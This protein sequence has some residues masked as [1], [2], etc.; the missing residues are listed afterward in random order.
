MISL[1]FSV[2]FA[3]AVDGGF[4]AHGFRLAAHDADARDPMVGWRPGS[5]TRHSWFASGVMEYANQPLV[6]ERS[7]SSVVEVDDQLVLNTSLGYAPHPRIRLD[8]GLPVFFYSRGVAG[9]IGP[10]L[11]DLR[12]TGL[13]S[14]ISPE[15]GGLGLGLVGNLDVPT[16]SQRD[17]RGQRTVAGGVGVAVTGELGKLTLSASASSQLRPNSDPA[18]RPAPTEGGDAFTWAASV[19][20]LVT[21]TT[22]L[23][24]EAYGEAASDREV[25]TALGI[26]VEAMLSMR[27]VRPSGGFLTAGLG[28][29]L[30]RGAGAS[31]FRLIVGGGFGRG[32]KVVQDM[33][34]DGFGDYDDLC[35]ASPET[36]N[37]YK[38]EDGCP[39]ELPRMQFRA[40]DPGGEY[41]EDATVAVTG[42]ENQT[43]TGSLSFQ[44]EAVTPGSQWHV[45]VTLGNCLA[46]AAD[47]TMGPNGDEVDVVLERK[48]TARVYVEAVDLQGNPVPNAEVRFRTEETPCAP[49]VQT[50]LPD[51]TAEVPV[52]P[53]MF[54][55]FVTAPGY[56]VHQAMFQME[57]SG[58]QTVRAVLEPALAAMIE[59]PDGT[60]V[61]EIREKVYFDTGKATILD[62]S[63]GLLDV[64]ASVIQSEGLNQV[65]VGGHTDDRGAAAANEELSRA[66]ADAVRTYLIG[67][68]VAPGLLTAV[69]YG[70]S[71]PLQSNATT[72]GRDAN[73]R[74]EFRVIE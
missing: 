45:E 59:R 74:V 38:D 35:P 20:Y 13:I 52:G 1:L 36:L 26:P 3:Q 2:A 37:G 47:V 5:M 55:A 60:R 30:S 27:H 44:G 72:A 50:P 70:E 56:R 4:D 41:R 32:A 19:G 54:F 25:R 65:E 7:G 33:D 51:G 17:Y 8:V 39:D 12:A 58:T 31:P 29:G 42:P 64:V 43:G 53:G 62:Q 22:G 11:G 40:I 49:N 61:I 67:K 69:G 23:N 15:S 18:L 71:R 48:R 24:V 34:G 57:P 73:R 28:V 63:F 10:T 6:F 9:P 21:E 66:R 68:G 46:G 16:G 14:L